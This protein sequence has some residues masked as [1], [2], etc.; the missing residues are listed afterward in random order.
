MISATTGFC[1][2]NDLNETNLS[3]AV[4]ATQ[5][6]ERIVS[7]LVNFKKYFSKIAPY[8]ISEY[9]CKAN[10]IPIHPDVKV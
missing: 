3:L 8:M 1:N 4:R 5:D 9:I 7:Q 6:L 10:M 2:Q